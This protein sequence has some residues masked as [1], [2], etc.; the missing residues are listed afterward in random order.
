M[1]EP[2][3]K[4]MEILPDNNTFLVRIS[5]FWARAL[6]ASAGRPA[7]TNTNK[8]QISHLIGCWSLFVAAVAEADTNANK[9]SESWE[10]HKVMWA[11]K[12][13][14]QRLQGIER[15]GKQWVGSKMREKMVVWR[16]RAMRPHMCV[17]R[18]FKCPNKCVV[19]RDVITYL[20]PPFAYLI[21][22]YLWTICT[23]RHRYCGIFGDCCAWV[24]CRCCRCV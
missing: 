14:Y 19:A 8:Q 10:V 13:L 11:H 7:E 3:G 24:W 2:I 17:P 15:K 18:K 21:L 1:W 4:G 5:M 12:P 9:G 6:F 20:I 16:E 23:S 22:R